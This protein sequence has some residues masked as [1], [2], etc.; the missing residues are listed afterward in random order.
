M[1]PPVD[2]MLRQVPQPAEIVKILKRIITLC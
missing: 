2:V 1:T